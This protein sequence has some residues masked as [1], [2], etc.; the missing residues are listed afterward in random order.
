MA[1]VEDVASLAISAV[2]VSA[3]RPLGILQVAKWVDQRYRELAGRVR[4]RQLRK[5][6]AIDIPAAIL[7]GTV[8][9]TEGSATL[10]ADGDA[11]TAIGATNIVGRHIRMHAVWYEITAYAAPNITIATPYAELAGAGLGFLLLP[12]FHTLDASARWLGKFVF[13][14]RRRTLEMRAAEALDRTAP[15]RLLASYGPLYVAEAP[16]ATSGAKRVEL[17]PYTK[18]EETIYYTYWAIPTTLVLDTVIPQ[19]VDPY[20]LREGV[21]IDV[22]R[23]RASQEANAGKADL[24]AY[25]R[26]E[27]RAQT[28]SWESQIMQATRADRGQDD[29]GFIYHILGLGTVWNRDI[30]TARDEIWAR[31]NRP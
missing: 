7:T 4:F 15:E 23:Y 16:N 24:A 25:W 10:V 18:T 13:P 5:V 27:Q 3:E 21:L 9:A 31:G 20:V 19:E 12:R 17:Y 11:Q 8:T 26:N 30:A 22:Y 2:D 14:R 6:G 28:T 1:T 29:V